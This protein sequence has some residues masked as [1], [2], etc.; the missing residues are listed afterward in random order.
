[1]LYMPRCSECPSLNHTCAWQPTLTQLCPSRISLGPKLKLNQI[2]TNYE[3][4]TLKSKSLK[5]AS[6]T[7][8]HHEVEQL[9][10]KAGWVQG[11]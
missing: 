11:G 3:K 10:G 5:A 7:V 4:L 9:V 8:P 2:Q 1:M 6:P